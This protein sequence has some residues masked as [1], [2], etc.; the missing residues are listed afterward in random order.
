LLLWSMLLLAGAS[1]GSYLVWRWS[2]PIVP[3]I[4]TDGLDAEVV[5]AVEQA[6]ADV[7][8][9]PR[10]AAAWGRLGMVLFAHD[11]YAESAAVLAE[12]ER[13]DLEDARWPYLRGLALIHQQ[14]EAG[15]AALKRAAAIAPF[16][17]PMQLRLAEEY[18]K[19]DR[20]D[21]ADTILGELRARFPSN[22]RVLLGQGQILARRGQWK[23]AL[24]PLTAAAP[25]PTSRRSAHVAMAEAYLRLNDAAAAESER[26]QAA[27]LPADRTWPDPLLAETEGLRTGLLPR[28][29]QALELHNSGKTHDGLAL[30]SQVLRDHPGSGRAHLAQAQLLVASGAP[31]PAEA[32]LRR[33]IELK[34]ELVHAHFLLGQTRSAQM[35]HAEAERCYLRT[36]E[37]MPSHALAHYYLGAMLLDDGRAGEAAAHLEIA[38]RLDAAND[39]ARALLA[40]ART[41]EAARK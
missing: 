10:S 26:Q 21:E 20:I 31:A 19:L 29:E 4:A 18:L 11:M 3:T 28:I 34:P 27:R 14:P 41:K 30:I 17:L 5:A 35:D 25:D 12:A 37:L 36:I 6:R 2:A 16:D 39:R 22:P 7:Q 13:L 8:A 24:M 40:Q 32:A 1:V 9:A 33:A 23:E 15:I 38:V